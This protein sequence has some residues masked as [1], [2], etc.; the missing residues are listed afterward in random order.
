MNQLSALAQRAFERG[1]I[2]LTCIVHLI[3]CGNVVLDEYWNPMKRTAKSQDQIRT[4]IQNTN[5]RDFP[6]LLS[7]SSSAAILNASGL[8]SVTMCKV[9]LT[10]RI[11]EI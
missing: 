4:A 8:S 1:P 9:E 3:H 2:T 11:L 5:P 7:V 6:A 10:S